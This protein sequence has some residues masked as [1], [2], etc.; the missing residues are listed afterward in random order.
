MK[1]SEINKPGVY[2]A[3]NLNEPDNR[4]L[5]LIGG[6]NHFLKI[7]TIWDLYHNAISWDDVRGK[8]LD[9]NELKGIETMK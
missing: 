7:E 8:S 4:Y 5:V 6:D 9:W 3:T 2:V 1:Q